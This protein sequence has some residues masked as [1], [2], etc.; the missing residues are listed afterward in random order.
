[1]NS[2]DAWTAFFGWCTVLNLGIYILSAGGLTLMRGLVYRINGKMFGLTEPDVA[3]VSVHY[4][5]ADK[6]LITVFCFVPWAAL[7]LMS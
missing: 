5:G 1:M 2:M 7:N 4:I 3:R 6:L